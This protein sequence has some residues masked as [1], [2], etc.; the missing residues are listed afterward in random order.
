MA[1]RLS[2]S[3]T[4]SWP[5][6][7][8]SVGA[9]TARARRRPGPAGRRARRQRRRERRHAP[10]PGA[11]PPHRCSRR[12]S[13]AGKIAP[14]AGCRQP[15]RRGEAAPA[16]DVED[17]L[18]CSASRGVSRSNRSVARPAA[19][20]LPRRP[21][22]AGA[23]AAAA[24][25]VGEEDDAAGMFGPRQ[26]TGQVLGPGTVTWRSPAAVRSVLMPA[27]SASRPTAGTGHIGVPSRGKVPIP[28]PDGPHIVG[29][30]R[31]STASATPG[32]PR[33]R[34]G[35]RPG[36]RRRFDG[37]R[38]RAARGPRPGRWPRW[39]VRRPP[40]APSAP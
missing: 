24:A 27:P 31:H 25:A 10:R 2:S 28:V 36:P 21:P 8:S 20:Q 7:I 6:T 12:S 4:S 33:H 26:R 18:A 3:T 16:G 14:R 35:S 11:P 34:P 13:R 39:P 9:R 37:G 29:H 19:A 5:P 23:Q 17:V 15:S 40:R 30:S 22:V 1:R 38:A 32:A